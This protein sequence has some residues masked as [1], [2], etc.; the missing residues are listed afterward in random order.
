MSGTRDWPTLVAGSV[1]AIAGASIA[2]FYS[3]RGAVPVVFV[4]FCLFTAGYLLA[5]DGWAVV[6]KLPVTDSVRAGLVPTHSGHWLVR[7]SLGLV[8]IFVI[9]T[10][11]TQ[12]SLTVMDP[13]LP[14]AV[15]AGVYSIGGYAWTH[16]LIHQSLF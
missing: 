5:R 16:V 7:A 13:S 4:G 3:F 6:G 15:E 9:S 12:F 2:G 8:G 14:S 11:V 1:L 10:G